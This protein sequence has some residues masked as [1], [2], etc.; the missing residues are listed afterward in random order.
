MN[1]VQFSKYFLSFK[2][3][4]STFGLMNGE[5]CLNPAIKSF[6]FM[7]PGSTN[8]HKCLYLLVFVDSETPTAPEINSSAKAVKPNC[9]CRSLRELTAADDFEESQRTVSILSYLN[10]NLSFCTTFF[11]ISHSF[12]GCF[13]WKHLINNWSYE[14]SFN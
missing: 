12:I 3:L 4:L 8:T 1:I 9:V 5:I 14:T 13:K 7:R 11:N 6:D 2:V 10:N